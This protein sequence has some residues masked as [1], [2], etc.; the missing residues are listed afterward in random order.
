MLDYA[1]YMNGTVDSII[2]DALKPINNSINTINNTINGMTG[3]INGIKQ[4]VD[5]HTIQLGDITKTLSN[6]NQSINGV[7]G[8][9][10]T[11]TGNIS[12][13]TNNISSMNTTLQQH[14]KDLQALKDSVNG[15]DFSDYLSKSK[16]GRV[17]GATHFENIYVDYHMLCR[18]LGVQQDLTVEAGC[19]FAVNTTLNGRDASFFGNV[20]VGGD[21]TCSG[22]VGQTSDRRLKSDIYV[23]DKKQC[24]DRVMQLSGCYFKYK[25]T[26]DRRH[27]GFI[28]QDV[29]KYFPDA[30]SLDK[31]TGYMS[32]AYSELIAPLYQAFKYQSER[33]EELE[34][35]LKTPWWKRLFR[36]K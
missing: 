12:G 21:F 6:I 34:R 16:G 23:I 35:Q 13:I 5:Q 26:L 33:I 19:Y 8:D 10:T 22:T 15:I 4:T 31:E 27:L 20:S 14:S 36:M 24:Y 2:A 25:N 3:D 28:A 30:V 11:I 9:I 32:V 18:K 1:S 29:K 7:K 17:I